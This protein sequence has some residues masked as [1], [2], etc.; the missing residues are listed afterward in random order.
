MQANTTPASRPRIPWTRW[1]LITLA[2]WLAAWLPLWLAPAGAAPTPAGSPSL[3]TYRVIQL[4]TD[5]STYGGSIN[6]KGQVAF[7]EYDNGRYH[8]RFYDGHRIR[9]LG[10]LGGPSAYG[11]AVNDL[12]QVAGVSEVSPDGSVTHAFRWSAA[13]GMVDLTP[14][15]KQNSTAADINKHGQVAGTLLGTDGVATH[16]F[17]WS[18]QTGPL[19]IGVLDAYSW[20]TAM[21]DA[22]AI[23]GYGGADSP[24]GV[25]GFL[26]TRAGG[27]RNVGT[28]PEEFTL[29]ADVNNLGH[30]VG[31][32]PFVNEPFPYYVHAFL[33]T[34]QTGPIDLGTGSTFESS[35]SAVNDHD[36]V[37]GR[38]RDFHI[39]DHGFVWTRAMGLLEFAAG[40]PEIGTYVGGLNNLDQVV[41]GYDDWAFFWTRA[42][43]LV[44]LNTRLVGAPAGFR[45]TG[46]S[47]ISDNGMIVANA[48]TGLVLLVPATTAGQAPVAGPI[49]P[50]G[51]PRANAGL[52]FAA[53]FT[54]G[55]PADTHK[56]TWDWGDGGSEPATVSEKRGTGSASGQH[57]FRT[58]GIHTVKLTVTDSSGRSATV[59][60]TVTVAGTG[61]YATGA[62]WFMSP[63]G[64]S[65]LAPNRAG[66]ATFAVAAPGTPDAARL[67]GGAGVEFR[68]AGLIFR[69]DRIDTV[70]LQD[71]RVQ[72]RGGGNVNGAPGYGFL[73]TATPGD[74]ANLR[75]RIWH[76]APGTKNEVVDYD[77]APDPRAAGSDAAGSAVKGGA[78]TVQS[79]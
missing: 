26:W 38:V 53:A 11:G 15:V 41:G 9:D 59:G 50:Q 42:S 47:A 16:G 60:K 63:L 21:N 27:I 10:T 7:T 2:A 14:A 33:W 12:G 20:A 45:L 48:N 74:K 1:R 4:S 58:P 56:A 46:A 78:M 71:G 13:T 67:R 29:A 39:F 62:G 28:L 57:V 43:G 22:G 76:V 5:P 3:P 52:T 70:T 18:P 19:S 35:A 32:T 25:L 72:Y 24:Q 65:R 30:V 8:A 23:V 61:A 17:L 79:G 75:I 69:S 54:D 34:P 55:D 64:A 37:V 68:A 36:M 73:L 66:I 6:G 51:T 40:H 44:D 31:A 49:Q 77:N